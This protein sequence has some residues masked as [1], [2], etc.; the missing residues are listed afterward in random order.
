[1]KKLIWTSILNLII[2][3][4][5]LTTVLFAWFSKNTQVNNGGLYFKVQ[6]GE[7]NILNTT[8]YKY[9]AD[10]KE[11]ITT[12]DF[13]LRPYDTI[14]KDRNLHSALILKIAASG[15]AIGQGKNLSI[16]LLCHDSQANTMSLSNVIEFRVG[17]FNI[18][19]TNQT[20]YST[21]ETSLANAAIYKFKTNTKVTEISCTLSNYNNYVINGVLS[22]YVYINYN[23]QLADGIDT[24]T[25]ADLDTTIT[26][27]SDIYE[28]NIGVIGE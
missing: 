25:S 26:F 21:V 7:I 18:N 1:M 27:I 20:I 13:I 23:E 22:I 5:C 19:G 14:I 8:I 28:L 15:E 2:V 12:N 6:Q 3:A 16:N 4:V 17:T 11:Y 10:D 9:D 24:L